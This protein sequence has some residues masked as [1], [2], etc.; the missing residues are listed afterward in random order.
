MAN[1]EL[2]QDIELKGLTGLGLFACYAIA[3]LFSG[4]LT[5]LLST[6]LADV[7][8]FLIAF[9]GGP[10]DKVEFYH[11]FFSFGAIYT[12]L[13]L[14]KKVGNIWRSSGESIGTGVFAIPNI[15]YDPTF[16]KSNAKV[17]FSY[18]KL[19]RQYHELKNEKEDILNKF[20]NSI[21]V[22]NKLKRNMTVLFRH[23]ENAI[24]LIDGLN[25]SIQTDK[26]P[27]PE[28]LKD[29][30]SES[31]TVL[32]RDMSDKSIS[33]FQVQ[34]DL[35]VIRDGIRINAESKEK[36][37][38]KKGEG[39]AG[40][41]WKEGKPSYDNNIKYDDDARFNQFEQPLRQRFKS[42]MGLP[43]KVD[44]TILGVLCIQSEEEEGFTPDDLRALEFYAN[45]CTL[46][47]IFDN[48]KLKG[49]GGEE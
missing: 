1:T 20:T 41:V 47:L 46:I 23:H 2:E 15:F 42:I 12:L 38:F 27:L 29:T 5:Y 8:G 48:I 14:C 26:Y 19:F 3:L 17:R 7:I 31:I 4:F 39:F 32:E 35:L 16:E 13:S 43:L 9:F 11:V 10:E 37:A 44:G 36:R 28:V 34:G 30:L 49:E 45:L 6:F 33:L 25:Y 18:Y 40:S 24:R 21:E 22:I